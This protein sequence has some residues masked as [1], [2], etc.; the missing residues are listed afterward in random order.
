MAK[1]QPALQITVSLEGIPE[2]NASLEGVRDAITHFL[3][4]ECLVRFEYYAV[5]LSSAKPNSRTLFVD[6]TTRLPGASDFSLK[7]EQ[8]SK[9]VTVTLYQ[10]GAAAK[11]ALKDGCHQATMKDEVM[12]STFAAMVKDSMPIS[13]RALGRVPVSQLVAELSRILK[14]ELIARRL[15]E[16]PVGQAAASKK[17]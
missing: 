3:Q 9:E 14:P 6:Y 8:G 16:L 1:N 2:A 13:T 10:D 7:L 15:R 17:S 11:C 12:G 5:P 4:A